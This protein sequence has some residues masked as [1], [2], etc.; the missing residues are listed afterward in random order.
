M[1]SRDILNTPVGPAKPL[2]E[3]FQ[4]P[5]HLYTHRIQEADLSAFFHVNKHIPH[6]G[7]PPGTTADPIICIDGNDF[8]YVWIALLQCGDRIDTR[9][10]RFNSRVWVKLKGQA[11][12]R[13]AHKRRKTK[14]QE[15][16]EAAAK[17]REEAG[18]DPLEEDAAADV[19]EDDNP[20]D[21][22]DIYININKAYL[23]MQADEDLKHAQFPVGMAVLLYILGGTDFFDDFMGDENSIFHGMGWEGNVWDTWCAHKD[24]F[25]NLIMLFYTGPAGY[26]QPE[27]CRRPYIDEKAMLTFFHQCYATKY[28]KA[29]RDIFDV[30]Q[31]TPAQLREFTRGFA[32]KCKRKAGEDDDKWQKRWLMSRKKAMP[33]DPIL[34]RYARLALLNW[35][36]WLN[37]YRPGGEAFCDPLELYE[38]LPYYGYLQDPEA[39]NRFTLSPI[40]SPPKPVPDT[41]LPYMGLHTAQARAAAQEAR[42]IAQE[43]MA[44]EDEHAK[45]MAREQERL[46][47][48]RKLIEKEKRLAAAQDKKRATPGQRAPKRAPPPIPSAA[49]TAAVGQRVVSGTP[50]A[51]VQ[52]RI[53]HTAQL[54]PV[55]RGIKRAPPPQ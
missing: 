19:E 16:R 31:V 8:D 15:A 12:A 14:A 9:T 25:A 33:E 48:Q 47:R 22:R 53:T 49:T 40:V 6:A 37:G 18:E 28:G 5:P 41:V 54:A 24:R 52:S 50:A 27:L 44:K 45:D 39:P 13:E 7:A 42:L 1:S 10:S 29:V 32:V 30:N 43:E 35:S 51:V 17:K 55:G 38:G 20:I 4:C 3:R 34:R 11:A 23:M 36:Y 2:T 26:N 46:Y 21:G